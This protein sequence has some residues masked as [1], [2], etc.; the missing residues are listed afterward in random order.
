MFTQQKVKKKEAP[1]SGSTFAPQVLKPAGKGSAT[2]ALLAE[3]LDRNAKAEEAAEA[4]R[5]LAAEKR[6]EAK[7]RQKAEE[8]NQSTSRCGC[9]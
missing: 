5:A 9:F 7:A 4:A 6:K 1:K 3:I 2:D 8:F